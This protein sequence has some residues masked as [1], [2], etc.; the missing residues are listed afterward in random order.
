MPSGGRASRSVRTTIQE[1][2][3]VPIDRIGKLYIHSSPYGL[4]LR[5][6]ACQSSSIYSR[7]SSISAQA[8]VFW[9]ITGIRTLI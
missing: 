1:S 8:S 5:S 2:A 7:K 9:K 6:C 3:E 4:C